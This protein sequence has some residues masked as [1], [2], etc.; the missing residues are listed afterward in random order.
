[1]QSLWQDDPYLS[2]Y[3][4]ECSRPHLRAPDTYWSG[5]MPIEFGM[6]TGPWPAHYGR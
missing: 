2:D 3:R 6:R 5:S 1:M 4:F